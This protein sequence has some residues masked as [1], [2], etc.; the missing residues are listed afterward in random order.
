[1]D[2]L[3]WILAAIGAMAV[4]S[5]IFRTA[6]HVRRIQ[7]C[8]TPGSL[9]RYNRLA[10]L[11]GPRFER[12]IEP[13]ALMTDSEI[14]EFKMMLAAVPTAHDR[15]GIDMRR[16]LVSQI[17]QTQR[18]GQPELELLGQMSVEEYRQLAIALDRL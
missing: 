6:W 4:A 7:E 11:L 13:L 12:L 17:A 10:R 18:L 14:V 15:T 1:M 3:I 8:G 16:R 9:P 2:A 5:F